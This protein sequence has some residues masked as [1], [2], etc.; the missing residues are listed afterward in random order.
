MIALF[1]RIRR[2][3]LA[4]GAGSAEFVAEKLLSG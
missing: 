1:G 2:V 4:A 3:L